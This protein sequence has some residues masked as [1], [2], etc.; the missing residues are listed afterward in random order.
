MMRPGRSLRDIGLLAVALIE[1]AAPA[2]PARAQ[3]AA[4]NEN[5]VNQL[6]ALEAAPD[7]DVAALRQQALDRVK[8]KA[9][10]T[11][12][13]RPPVAAQLRKLPQFA[14]DVQFDPDTSIV[15]PQS[16]G[17]LGRIADVLSHPTLLPY[18]FLIVGHT[19]ATGRRDINLALSQKRADSVRDVLVT[20]FKISPK[21]LKAIG[22]GEEQLL[23]AIHPTAAI[24][25]QIQVVSLGPAP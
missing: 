4:A 17:T 15:R 22:L 16:Y 9:D 2:A 13:R 5:L 23:D 12:L 8:S 7:L 20:T 24:N 6:A 19:D 21:R 10:A 14:V 18:S 3:P 1:L 25:Q 11:P